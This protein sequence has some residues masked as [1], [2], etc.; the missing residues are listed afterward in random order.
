MTAQNTGY[1]GA[2][3]HRIVQTVQAKTLMT[4]PLNLNGSRRFS[5]SAIRV[6]SSD[7]L[8]ATRYERCKTERS[9]PCGAALPMRTP[10]GPCLPEHH[11]V[12]TQ[13]CD[14]YRACCRLQIASRLWL[15][16]PCHARF[17]AEMQESSARTEGDSRHSAGPVAELEPRVTVPEARG[18]G[19]G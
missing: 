10:R 6:A 17:H 1:A 4:A 14:M 8:P 3:A 11:P 5:L 15:R 7:V 2:T 12:C 18:T 16:V 19:P 13:G 9:A